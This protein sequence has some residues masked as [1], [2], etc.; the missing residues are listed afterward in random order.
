M[1]SEG[2]LII[3][4]AKYEGCSIFNLL[5]EFSSVADHLLNLTMEDIDHLFD[6]QDEYVYI[7]N[8]INKIPLERINRVKE[9]LDT[10]IWEYAG[11]GSSTIEFE[12]MKKDLDYI[13]KDKDE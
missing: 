3:L 2:N 11:R 8:L 5:S 12:I 6:F 13:T 10:L 4:E 1:I 9:N 7:I